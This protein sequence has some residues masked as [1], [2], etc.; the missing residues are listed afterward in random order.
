MINIWSA[1][2]DI[3]LA[4]NAGMSR[5]VVRLPGS[6]PLVILSTFSPLAGSLRLRRVGGGN[7]RVQRPVVLVAFV[8][9]VTL[10]ADFLCS[11][12][13]WSLGLVVLSLDGLPTETYE[14]HLLHLL[15]EHRCLYLLIIFYLDSNRIP[16]SGIFSFGNSQKLKGS[17]PE[18]RE[19]EKIR[20]YCDWP[21]TSEVETT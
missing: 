19:P 16:F 4:L 6:G 8:F 14:S 12:F 1:S 5:C 13:A 17:Y 7:G 3:V 10:V 15:F 11:R 2:P 20:Q 9:N 21:E 18:I